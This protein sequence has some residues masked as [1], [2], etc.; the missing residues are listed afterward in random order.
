MRCVPVSIALVA[1]FAGSAPTEAAQSKGYQLT[2]TLAHAKVSED[3]D[4]IWKASDLTPFGN[5]AHLPSIYLA[6]L[7]TSKGEWI[8]SMVDNQCSPQSD[9]QAV[10][11]FR[12]KDGSLKVVS[13][14]SLVMG[15]TATLSANFKTITTEEVDDTANAFT[16]KYDVGTP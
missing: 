3:P 4:G 8:L 7:K 2:P 11:A 16:G 5:P 1:A 6:I 14:P 12:G 13:N 10:L 9:C 15:G